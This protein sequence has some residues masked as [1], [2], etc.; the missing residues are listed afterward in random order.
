MLA[1][2]FL[3]LPDNS[4]DARAIRVLGYEGGWSHVVSKFERYHIQRMKQYPQQHL[5][6]LIDFDEQSDR[7]EE[8]CQ[9]IPEHIKDRV[10]VIGSWSNPE[11]LRQALGGTLE[12]IGTTLA[13]ECRDGTSN[14]WAHPLL[15]HNAE[16]LKRMSE[17]L[18]SIIFP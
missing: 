18:K 4:M 2:G 16:E 13:Q 12:S 17:K 10:F 11:K 5:V 9:R 3:Q 6:L 14:Y 1:N 8:I 15:K 7:F